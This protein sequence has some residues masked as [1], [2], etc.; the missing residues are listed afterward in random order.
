MENQLQTHLI[1]YKSLCR[2]E[3]DK[4][5][6]SSKNPR[7]RLFDIKQWNQNI[8]QLHKIEKQESISWVYLACIFLFLT[9]PVSFSTQPLFMLQSYCKKAIFFSS[10]LFSLFLAVSHLHALG[11]KNHNKGT[12]TNFVFCLHT[13]TLLFFC[14]LLMFVIFLRWIHKSGGYWIQRLKIRYQFRRIW[15]HI[16]LKGGSL[17]GDHPR[18]ATFILNEHHVFKFALN[19]WSIHNWGWFSPQ[20]PF[21]TSKTNEN[22]RKLIS[23]L[24]TF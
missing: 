11:N 6:N 19:E 4:N 15:W 13:Q 22:L 23:P 24:S 5:I 12:L 2:T 3:L 17:M 10:T 9:F 20:S 16:L 7:E 18:Q 14:I 1:F 21:A 8:K